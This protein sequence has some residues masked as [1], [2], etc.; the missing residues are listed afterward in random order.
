MAKTRKQ[1]PRAIRDQVLGEFNYRC[2][3]CGADH[4]QIHHIDH[5]PSNNDPI[6]LI[7]LCPNCHLTDQHAPTKDTEPEK[8][9]LFREYKDPTILKPQ[10]H[11][12]FVRLNFLK[13]I[14]DDSDTKELDKKATELIEFISELEMG[15]F[16]ARRLTELIRKP[17]YASSTSLGERGSE[18]RYREKQK[19]YDQEYRNQLYKARNTVYTLVVEL[20]RYQPW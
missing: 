3:I 2:A 5:D 16:Y 10:F 17:R 15:T 1:A 4:P 6:N 7:P 18:L 14:E 11:P 12:L 19:E 9:R 13:V 20:L 8:L